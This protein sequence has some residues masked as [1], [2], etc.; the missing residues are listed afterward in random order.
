M[1]QRPFDQYIIKKELNIYLSKNKEVN[2]W[3]ELLNYLNNGG[4]QD[5]LRFNCVSYIKLEILQKL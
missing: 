4:V 3:I 1:Q 2:F 5:I